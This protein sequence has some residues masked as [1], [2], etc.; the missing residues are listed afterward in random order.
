[1][2]LQNGDDGLATGIAQRYSDG[3]AAW[4]TTPALQTNFGPASTSFWKQVY[5]DMAAVMVEAGV[6]P[7]LQFGEVQWWYF[8]SAAGMPF[9]DD[10]TTG[11]F[12]ATYGYPMAI[13]GSE[14]ANPDAFENECVHLPKLIGEFTSTVMAFVRHSYPDTRFEVLYPP[15]VNDTALNR[16][17]NFP[18]AT[19]TAA[20]LACLKT[21]NFIYT[22][23]R[24]LDKAR[25]SILL[26]MTVGF[27]SSQ[28]SH[29]VGIGE[30]TTPWE[31][32]QRLALGE[33]IESVVLFALDQ[34]CLV[35]YGLRPDR[36]TGRAW[37]QGE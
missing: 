27:P 21:E 16:I 34:F 31:K 3:G 4:L 1:M 30:Y 14:N 37:Y 12:E 11:S 22:G 17:V 33:G 36:A 28:S 19:W 15:D 35:G 8:A 2:E 20:N 5:L 32:E 9:Y 13:I 26:P 18:A 25:S 29:L 24:D 10:Y 23:N 6:Q 7:Y